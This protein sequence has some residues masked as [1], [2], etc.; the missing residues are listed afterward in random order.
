M[1]TLQVLLFVVLAFINLL[2]VVS[3]FYITSLIVSVGLMIYF[4]YI[5]TNY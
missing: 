3:G 1:I 5:L 2:L 4:V